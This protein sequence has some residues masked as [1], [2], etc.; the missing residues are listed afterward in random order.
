MSNHPMWVGYYK[1]K[2]KTLDELI[3]TDE[4]G[5]NRIREWLVFSFYPFLW[6]EGEPINE[7]HRSAVPVREAWGVKV[8]LVEQMGQ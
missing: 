1:M 5:I 4:P 3:E 7:R 2:M 8:D 6:A